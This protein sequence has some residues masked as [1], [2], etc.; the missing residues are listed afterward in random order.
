[1]SVLNKKLYAMGLSIA[2][3]MRV[4]GKVF[5]HDSYTDRQR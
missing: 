3:K 4:G 1:M 2:V 5:R